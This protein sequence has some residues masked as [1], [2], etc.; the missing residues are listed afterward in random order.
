MKLGGGDLLDEGLAETKALD[1]NERVKTSNG[2]TYACNVRGESVDFVL[3]ERPVREAGEDV[4][5]VKAVEC[6]NLGAVREVGGGRECAYSSD[7]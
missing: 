3:L 2:W 4:L 7:G 1:G 6:G 5:R